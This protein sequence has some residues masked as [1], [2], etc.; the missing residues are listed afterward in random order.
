MGLFR[1]LAQLVR[2]PR[3]EPQKSD[4]LSK[5]TCSGRSGR[6]SPARRSF[7]YELLERREMLNADPLSFG[8]V[9]L[10]DATLGGTDES[11]PGDLL[12]VTFQGGAQGTQ[13]TELTVE[14]NPGGGPLVGGDRFFDTAPGGGGT[15]GYVPLSVVSAEGIDSVQIHQSNQELDGATTLT[16]SL[17]GFEAGDRLVLGFDNDE[18][19]DG[20]TTPT[21]EGIEFQGSTITGTFAAETYEDETLTG[22]FLDQYDLSGTNL[23][24]PPDSYVPPATVDARDFTAGAIAQ[25]NQTPLPISLSGRVFDDLNVNNQLDAGEQGV[26]GVTLTLQEFDGTNYVNQATT[27][28]DQ[29]GHYEFEGLLPGQYRVVETQPDGYFSVGATAGQVEGDPRGVVESPNVISE[30]SLV[31]GEHSQGNNFAEALPGSLGGSVFHD[32]NSNG[33]FDDGESGISGVQVTL[34][35]DAG[36]TVA[37]TTT[38]AEGGYLF[39][40]LSPGTYT[41]VQTQP[42]GFLDGLDV[43]GSAGGFAENPGDQISNISLASGTQAVDYNFGELVPASISGQVHA[44]LDGDCVLDPGETPLEGVTIELLDDQGA[45]IDVTTTG[46]DGTYTFEDLL[47][48][49]YSVREVQP[50]GLFD[51]NDHV[52]DAGGTLLGNDTISGIVLGSGQQATGY[53]FCEVPPAGLSGSVYLDSN[54]DGARN[55]GE[56]GLSGV[57]LELRDAAGNLVATTTTDPSGSY[58]FENL[59]AGEYT[60][61]EIQPPG[62]FDGLDTVGSAGGVA[63]NPGDQISEI[64]L[65]AGVHAVGY[66]F[67]EL[68]PAS[69]SGTVHADLDG[70]CVL[71]PGE[72]PLEGVTIELLDAQGDLLQTTT[73]DAAGFYSFEDLPP[74]TYGIREVQPD[75]LLNGAAQ[76]GSAGGTVNGDTITGITVGSGQQAIGYHFCEVPP[77]SL[78]GDVYVDTNDNGQIDPGETGVAGAIV[79][80][81]DEQGNLV[82]STTTDSTGSYSFENL[83]PG[84]YSLTQVQPTGLFDG[85]DTPGTAGG[86]ALNPGDQITGVMLGAGVEATGYNFGELAPAS[87]SGIVHADLDGDCVL[88]PGETPL[89]GVTIELLDAQG[90]LLQTTTTDAAGFYSFE[91][92]PPGTYGIREVQPDGLLNGAAQVG[93][94]GGTVNGDTITGITVGSGQ[95][96]IGYHFCEVPPASLSGDVYVDTNDNGQIDPGETG[97]AGAIVELL[98]EQ[99]NLVAS[100]TTDS[101][102]SYSFEN[103]GP[104]EYSLTQVQPTG[105]FDG[106]DTPGTAGGT[107]LNP[108]DQIT[109]V[110]L[111]A[112]VEATGYNFGELAPASISGIVHADL[113]GDCIQDDDEIGVAGVTVQLLGADGQVLQTTTTDENGLYSFEELPP[114]TYGIQEI[115]PDGFFHQSE[116]IGT[117]GGTVT[118][119]DLVTEIFLGSGQ[120]ATG[121]NFCEVPHSSIE[122]VVFQ[123]GQTI[124]IQQ[125]E[126]PDVA[127]QRD[128]Q[129]TPD[130]TPLAGAV[131]MLTDENGEVI[132][133]ADE[134]PIV[135]VTD[136]QGQFRFDAL[137]AGTYGL[138]QVQP[139]GYEDWLETP[140]DAGGT[141]L[142]PGDEILGINLAAGQQASGYWF[143]E[144]LTESE[145]C[146]NTQVL[147][148]FGGSTTT[149][150][151]TF[152]G[153]NIPVPVP[154]GLGGGIAQ[155]APAASSAGYFLPLPAFEEPAAEG[156]SGGGGGGGYSWH[157][158]VIDGGHPRGDALAQGLLGAGQQWTQ[159]TAAELAASNWNAQQLDA[160]HWILPTP[161]ESAGQ[162]GTQLPVANARSV[163]FG[164]SGAVPV[165][166]DFDGDGVDDVGVF[167]QGEW[168]ID[169]NANGQWDEG[170]LWA[171]LGRPEDQPVTGDWNGD[172]K[173]DIGVFGPPWSGD[174]RAVEA[175]PGLPGVGNV[176]SGEPK[177]LPPDPDDAPD[178]PRFLKATRDGSLRVDLID[179]SFAYGQEGDVALAGDWDGDG[180]AEIGLYRDGLWLLD[181]NG[182]GEFDSADAQLD[183]SGFPGKPIVGDW[184]GDG[185]DEVGIY[186]EGR[187]VLDSN[188]DRRLDALDR[189]YELG[190]PGDHPVVGDWDGDGADQPGLYRDGRPSET[191]AAQPQSPGVPRR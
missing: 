156:G 72:T 27:T 98:D 111:G 42:V 183:L 94:A 110:M 103:L 143:S 105:L 97:V 1:L 66:D 38:D 150:V 152:G 175:E 170:D 41:L 71:D 126:I 102:G 161:L 44:D 8:A 57:T 122:G 142:N 149:L 113:D 29:T 131:V 123:D 78:S 51:G 45:V 181:L 60:I 108:G 36:Q 4:E 160:G 148:P 182:N 17:V 61:T 106:Q 115:Q 20:T 165:S 43:A 89:E 120:Q 12:E 191:T 141:A 50:D 9:Y 63:A 68:A 16:I 15:S 162:T 104:G 158:S 147:P 135:A 87:I 64:T 121:Y 30:V 76:V 145:C 55:V 144:V 73:T 155:T 52:G 159:L 56:S 70:D 80:L 136:A 49:V 5:G 77:A 154:G 28:T 163:V 99:G 93:S 92:L 24:L 114:G 130:D 59:T 107:A 178:V 96:A 124:V 187:W 32:A 33:I 188:G 48:G 171:K 173:T 10:E 167:Y 85:Q 19:G 164:M 25:T 189:V 118:G 180:T 90:D 166:G 83:G 34:L 11:P 184:N 35:D 109:G 2:S 14:L 132:T 62:L 151:P 81:L 7:R 58:T 125:G 3:R 39:D 133:G 21:V 176:S 26:G 157:L 82:A 40:D 169:L 100:T 185:V 79:E 95:Q 179:H 75:G 174:A 112:G 74:G 37:T 177:N 67:G 86:T 127:S 119:Q 101:T 47:P 134:Q 91:D 140:G 88:D 65:G 153:S 190:G 172:G 13:L 31:G 84:E 46:A 168:Y 6:K 23:D 129:L 137:H 138:V 54:N 18:L 117:A 69:I 128:G 53:N 186:D 139:L 146:D 116:N 22:T